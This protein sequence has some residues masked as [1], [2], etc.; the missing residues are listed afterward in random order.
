MPFTKIVPVGLIVLLGMTTPVMSQLKDSP[1]KNGFPKFKVQE[2]LTD[3]TIGYAVITADV[4][5]DGKPDIVI[6]DKHRVLWLENPTWKRR[7]ILEGK[8]KPDNVC[9]AAGDFDGDGQIDFVIGAGW[10]PFDTKTPGTLQWVKRG[11]TLDDE[12]TIY[13]I[14]CDEPT[15]HRVQVGDI[16]HDG[17]P[18]II[19]APLMGRDSTAAKNWMDGRPVRILSY[20]TPADPT[21]PENWKPKVISEELHIVHG[22]QL[23]AHLRNYKTGNRIEHEL[24]TASYEGVKNFVPMENNQT[25]KWRPGTEPVRAGDQSKPM[26]NRGSSEVNAERV[27]S[28]PGFNWVA[29]IEPWHGNSLVFYRTANDEESPSTTVLPANG[30]HVIDDHLRWGHAV[31]L[32]DLD[33]DGI[34]EM[35]VGVRDDPN[36]KLGDTFTERR[37]VRIYKSTDGK[38]KKWD[39]LILEDGG[40]AVEDLTVC[41]LNGD[42]KPDIIAVGRATGNCRIYWNQGK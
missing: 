19:L 32:M 42:G 38:G 4:N 39:R 34:P 18:D 9:I 13:P 17:K 28:W 15:V 41:D 20:P 8:T 2:V 23:T 6:V 37:G 21:K 22:I 12:W 29:S 26:A 40:V 7:I 5:G 27:V 24:F 36:A 33:G 11:K 14:P 35:I 31:K 10:T 25:V 16:D 30:R 1:Q 3:L